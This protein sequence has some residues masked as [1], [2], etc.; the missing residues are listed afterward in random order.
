M[1]FTRILSVAAAIVPLALAGAGFVML[2]GLG[3]AEAAATV[4]TVAV[5][6]PAPA[7]VNPVCEAATWPNIPAEC[8]DGISETP[9]TVRFQ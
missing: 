8:L 4:E 7:P 1:T 3:S 2:D 9:R 5:A 6:A